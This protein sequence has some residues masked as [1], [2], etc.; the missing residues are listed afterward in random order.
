M[1]DLFQASVTKLSRYCESEKFK[2]YDP[3]DT[4]NSFVPFYLLGKMGQM[5]AIQIQKR[6]LVNLRPLLGIKKEHN[7]KGMGLLLKAYCNLYHSSGEGRCLDIANSIFEWLKDNYSKGYSGHAWGYNFDWASS[8]MYLPA[9]TPSV[10]VTAFVVD[11][12][13]EY[14]SITK[15]SKAKEIIISASEYVK[16]DI[17]VT[18]FEN[19]VAFSYSHI[20][21]DCCYNASLLAAEILARSDYLNNLSTFQSLI[22]KAVDFVISKQHENGGWGYSFNL[23]NGSERRQTD[24][25]QGFILVSLNNLNNLGITPKNDINA[26]VKKGLEYYRINQFTDSGRALWRIPQKWPVDIHNQSQGIITFSRL[27]QFDPEYINFSKLIAK[28]TL[29]EMQSGNGYFYY[30]KMPL[31]TNKIP[32]IRWAQAWMLLALSELIK[33]NEAE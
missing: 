17:P 33:N 15:E 14:Y 4:L 3:Y 25:H 6:N 21:A 7:P 20:A 28:W 24:F 8:E 30:R 10:V 11:G 31:F 16:R 19:G 18:E 9:F 29:C 26:A 23:A 2:G 1:T 27:K 32:Y 13:F 5:I 22:Q 12:I